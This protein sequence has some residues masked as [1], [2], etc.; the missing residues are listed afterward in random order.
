MT[1]DQFSITINCINRFFLFLSLPPNIVL[2]T[3]PQRRSEA[4]GIGENEISQ[5]RCFGNR[6]KGRRLKTGELNEVLI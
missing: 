4:E 6:G 5:S 2:L 1:Y 3:P